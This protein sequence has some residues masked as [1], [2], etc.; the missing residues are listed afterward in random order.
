MK[1]TFKD[2]VEFANI[3][4]PQHPLFDGFESQD[5]RWLS[6]S[7]K[8]PY[9]AA[10]SYVLDENAPCTILP[11]HIMCRLK[12]TWWEV[13]WPET[14]KD[15]LFNENADYSYLADNVFD[16]LRFRP[17]ADL[18]LW[19][20]MYG[21]SD[22]LMDN[23]EDLEYVPSLSRLDTINDDWEYLNYDLYSKD[24]DVY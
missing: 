5:L 23:M 13:S 10:S 18:P 16:V 6:G 21:F 1:E 11:D 17:D 9:A 22:H 15:K 14:N 4:L 19:E 24:C 8:S 3:E 7:G 12:D 20:K 2:N